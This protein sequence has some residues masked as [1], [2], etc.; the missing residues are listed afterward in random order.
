MRIER[1]LWRF[2][3][4]LEQNTSARAD[5]PVK[6]LRCRNIYEESEAAALNILDLVQNGMQ[7][8]EIA[9]V[10]RD[11]ET[12]RGVLDAAMERHGI[13]FFLSE[14]TDFSQKPSA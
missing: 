12:Y 10:V 11:T 5:S 6:L 9:V 2:D 3:A 8:G 7:Y 13:P 1:D 4:P 14:R